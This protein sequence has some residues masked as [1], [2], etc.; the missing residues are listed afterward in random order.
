MRYTLFSPWLPFDLIYTKEMKIKYNSF[1]LLSVEQVE[2]FVPKRATPSPQPTL[3][4]MT[5]RK[6]QRLQKVKLPA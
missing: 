2:K 4:S 1:L 5:L 6:L 3:E